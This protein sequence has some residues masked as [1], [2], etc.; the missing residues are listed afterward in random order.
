M[1]KPVS[2][3]PEAATGQ[4]KSAGEIT[5]KK[6][7]GARWDFSVRHVDN[8]LRQG[9]PHLKIGKRR[10][11]IITEEADSWMRERFGTRR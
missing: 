2:F 10:V 1:T 4:L 5:D 6:G 7:F 3:T 11:R 9:M 8:L